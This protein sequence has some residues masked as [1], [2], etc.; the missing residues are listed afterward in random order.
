VRVWC[1]CRRA[2]AVQ[3]G[4][5]FARNRWKMKMVGAAVGARWG[6]GGV[7]W[8]SHGAGVGRLPV[9][10]MEPGIQTTGEPGAVW[11]GGACGSVWCGW[12]VGWW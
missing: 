8:R 7:G 3:G 11:V 4:A 5:A 10:A 1:K 2:A 6:N 9:G 12:G